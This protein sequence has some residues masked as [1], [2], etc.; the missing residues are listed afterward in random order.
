MHKRGK[1]IFYAYVLKFEAKGMSNHNTTQTP[2]GGDDA[3]TMSDESAKS[4]SLLCT[5]MRCVT[6]DLTR[7][8][9]PCNC[10]TYDDSPAWEKGG[11]FGFVSFDDNDNLVLTTEVVA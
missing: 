2:T 7:V 4:H 10:G 6:Y 11:I 9:Q 1:Y 3:G 8:G 5:S